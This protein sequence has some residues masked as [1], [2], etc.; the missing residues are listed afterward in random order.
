LDEQ[1]DCGS[2]KDYAEAKK[3]AEFLNIKLH[4]VKQIEQY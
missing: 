1:R 2:K 3:V 4:F